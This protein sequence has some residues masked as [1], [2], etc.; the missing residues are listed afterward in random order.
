MGWF[1]RRRPS[2]QVPGA[3]RPVGDEGMTM[4]AQQLAAAAEW[5]AHRFAHDDHEAVWSRRLAIGYE[6]S[7]DGL[8]A[9]TWFWFNAHAAL[10]ALYLGERAHPFVATCAGYADQAQWDVGPDAREAVSEIH[11]RYFVS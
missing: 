9:D 4:T 7:P 10:S 1:S 2:Q 6:A 8:T 5:M 3:V 11:E